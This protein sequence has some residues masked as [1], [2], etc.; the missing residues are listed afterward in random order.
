[1]R[2]VEPSS[3][4]VVNRDGIDIAWESF[5]EGDTPI[6]LLPSPSSSRHV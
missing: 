6:V 3:A 5:G 2:A 1:M 4:G